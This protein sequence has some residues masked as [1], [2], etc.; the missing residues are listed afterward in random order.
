MYPPLPSQLYTWCPSLFLALSREPLPRTFDKTSAMTS[1]SHPIFTTNQIPSLH[2]SCLP[3]CI[4]MVEVTLQAM[5]QTFNSLCFFLTPDS[6]KLDKKNFAWHASLAAIERMTRPYAR[7]YQCRL[8]W[9]KPYK[10]SEPSQVHWHQQPWQFLPFSFYCSLANMPILHFRNPVPLEFVTS[11]YFLANAILIGRTPPNRI[12]PC[13]CHCTGIYIP[14]TLCKRWTY[15]PRL[16]IFPNHLLHS[17]H[18]PLAAE[19]P[20]T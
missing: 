3:T 20:A 2:Y 17:S 8:W 11:I 4:N 6:P 12:D 19:P 16:L 14:E 1:T 7:Q 5:G 13:L 15:F 9:C 18:Y 10:T